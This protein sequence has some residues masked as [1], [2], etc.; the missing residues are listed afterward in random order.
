MSGGVTYFRFFVVLAA[1]LTSSIVHATTLRPLTEDDQIASAQTIFC[2]RAEQ[3]DSALETIAQ[4]RR[5]ITTVR[6]APLAVYKGS[7]PGPVSL[8]FLGGK[9]GDLE[10]KVGGM[11]E[12][13][14]GGEYILFVS[15]KGNLACPIVGW[16]DGSLKVDRRTDAGGTV[17]VSTDVAGSTER[18]V[19]ARSRT[20]LKAGA[21]KLPDFESRLRRRIA[22]LKGAKP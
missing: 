1:T 11:P 5:I 15:G 12:F 10:L 2:G 19:I 20:V 14:V 3:V 9:V 18:A 13:K 8:R 4:G 17:S 7:A 16:T 22:E 6:F 21:Q